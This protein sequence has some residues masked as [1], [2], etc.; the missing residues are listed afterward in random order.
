M[1]AG[2]L[3]SSAI[4]DEPRIFIDHMAYWTA[5]RSAEEARYLTAVL[6]SGI[7]VP[8]IVSMPPRGAGG[9]RHFDKLVWELPVPEFDSRQPLHRQLS[10]AAVEAE[11]VASLVELREGA[12]FT[13]QRRAIRDALAAD[14]IA[15]AIDALVFRLLDR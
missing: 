8:R 12:Y 9:P 7:I 3:L 10:D 5:A 13:T 15:A 1:K 6:N 2:T 11:R 4:V 14:G